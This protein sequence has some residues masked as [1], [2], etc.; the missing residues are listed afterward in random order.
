MRFKY[1]DDSIFITTHPLHY[2]FILFMPEENIRAVRAAH[3][4]FAFWAEE[5]D[6]FDCGA[7]DMSLIFV[8]VRAKCVI[9]R[10]K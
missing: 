6:A 7:V 1:V 9:I 8:Y 5:V 3:D 2:R 4:V 10:V